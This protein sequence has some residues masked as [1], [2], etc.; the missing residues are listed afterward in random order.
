MRIYAS[1]NNNNNTVII[2]TEP[3]EVSINNFAEAVLVTPTSGDLN[4]EGIPIYNMYAG[5][6]R[7]QDRIYVSWRKCTGHD[8]Y[9]GIVW[10]AYSDDEGETWSTEQMIYDPVHLYTDDPTILTQDSRSLLDAR[11]TRLMISN[12]GNYLFM[13]C[14]VSIGYNNAGTG[15]GTGV[16][17]VGRNNASITAPWRS[18]SVRYPIINGNEI[19]VPNK[20]IKTV[21]AGFKPFSGGYLSLPDNSILYSCYHNYGATTERGNWIYKSTDNGVTWNEFSR[22]GRGADFGELGSDETAWAL[23]GSVITVCSRSSL[24]NT[25]FKSLDYG[26]TWSSGVRIPYFTTGLSSVTMPD[27]LVGVFGRYFPDMLLYDPT[28]L[29][30]VENSEL[31][32]GTSGYGTIIKYMDKYT[33]AYTNIDEVWFR[34]LKYDSVNKKFKYNV[35]G[36]PLNTSVLHSMVFGSVSGLDLTLITRFYPFDDYSYKYDMKWRVY[37]NGVLFYE[38]ESYNKG[39]TIVIVSSTYVHLTFPIEY[40]TDYLFTITNIDDDDVESNPSNSLAYR[41]DTP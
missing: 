36:T 26:L 17:G 5:Q 37:N 7:V 40:D 39:G 41:L 23:T 30:L 13:F 12:D 11:D 16:V 18:M 9:D 28:D 29:S 33:V 24:G 19:D 15:P 34:Q 1:G 27:G 38:T 10:M 4:Y 3:D 22:L 35:Q 31:N 2:P 14:F 32:W 25:M 21:V 20:L 6:A 8:P